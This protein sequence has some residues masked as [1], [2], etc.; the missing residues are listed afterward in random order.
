MGGEDW[1]GRVLEGSWESVLRDCAWEAKDSGSGL[2]V[3]F[4]GV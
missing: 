4:F 1:G 3:R 2:L